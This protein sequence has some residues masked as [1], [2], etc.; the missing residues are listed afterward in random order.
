MRGHIRSVFLSDA[1]LGARYARAD[2][3]HEFLKWAD[4]Q[5]PERVYLVGDFI[6]GWKLRRKVHWDRSCN[7]VLRKIFSLLKHDTRVYYAA[8]NHD[9]FLRGF[10]GELAGVDFAGLEVADEFL[11]DRPNGETLLVIHGDKFDAAV[12]YASRTAPFMCWLGDAGYDALIV[13]NRAVHAL[14]RRLGLPYWSLSAAVKGQ[15]KNA[16]NFV[17]GFERILTDYARERDC[18]GVV[19]GHIHTAAVKPLRGMMYY[20]CGDWVESC[21][22]LIEYRDGRIELVTHED[23]LSG[24]LGDE[25]AAAAEPA[26]PAAPQ[27]VG[28]WSAKGNRSE[29]GSVASS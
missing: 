18:A 1:H 23:L 24:R 28:A 11:H 21:T 29:S 14:R 27:A 2:L 6:D 26:E 17:G 22:A 9:E 19:C 8:G 25:P 5:R 4:K 3:L 13:V 20:N 7:L 10:L 16:V 12:R 15:F